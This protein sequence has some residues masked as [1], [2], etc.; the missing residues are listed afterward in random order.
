MMERR[1]KIVQQQ[2]ADAGSVYKKQE[3]IQKEDTAN[4]SVT[5]DSKTTTATTPSSDSAKPQ[6]Y[7]DSDVFYV[8]VKVFLEGVQV[9]HSSAAVSYGTNNPPSATITIPAASFLRDLP[10][11]TK[12]HIIY[13]DL[14]P[15]SSGVYKWRLLF[16]GELEGLSYS[17]DSTGAYIT[18]HAFHSS[19][20]LTIMQIINQ[21]AAQYLYMREYEMIGQTVFKTQA[22]MNKIQISQINKI[23]ETK[24]YKSMADLTY[25]ILR[26]LLEGYKDTSAVSK[27]YWSKLGNDKNGFKIL[28]RIYGVS[29][30]AK[31]SGLLPP[32][33]VG[34]NSAASS[35]NS[36][37]NITPDATQSI[38]DGDTKISDG[39]SY[40][41]Y[42]VN[43]EVGTGGSGSKSTAIM[44]AAEEKLNIPY[45]IGGNGISSTDCGQ[46]VKDCWKAAGV[47]WDSRYVP[48][49]VVEA[50]QKGIWREAD[51]S[52]NPKA[53]DAIVVE[54]NLN[55]IILSDG[56]GGNYAASSSQGRT[57]HSNSTAAGYNYKITGYIA[58]N[59]LK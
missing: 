57:I 3:E 31:N 25:K 33:L 53:G 2:V 38:R 43:G 41:Q 32:E 17:I 48:D 49:M 51:G 55:H 7:T 47:E 42:T 50:R 26:Q 39:V 56:K 6:G 28:K 52:Y 35:S 5:G 18:L 29:D 59:D 19:A 45:F 27:W 12:V 44:Q 8:E 24:E 46:Y 22:G 16:D 10:E 20:Y 11:T 9:P 37:S 34:Q 14:M 58:I 36:T 23:I 30:T 40:N 13:K 1:T 21:A 54:N 4:T 15:D